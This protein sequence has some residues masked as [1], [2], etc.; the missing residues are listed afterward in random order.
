MIFTF[1]IAEVQSTLKPFFYSAI[2]IL[3]CYQA[4]ILKSREKKSKLNLR[5]NNCR[6]FHPVFVLHIAEM[7]QKKIRVQIEIKFTRVTY[8]TAVRI[9]FKHWSYPKTSCFWSGRLKKATCLEGS[10]SAARSGPI[11][12]LRRS[13][14]SSGSRARAHFPKQRLVFGR[15]HL[16]RA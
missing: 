16:L 4:K 2:N 15:Y 14:K 13:D 5:N 6:Q 3:N 9:R 1:K 12:E 11:P 10:I 7:L 8:F